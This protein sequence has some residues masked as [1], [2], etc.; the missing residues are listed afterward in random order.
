MHGNE[1]R[2][3]RPLI[4][5][6]LICLDLCNIEHDVKVLGDIGYSALHIDIVDGRFSPSMP[7]GLEM[8]RQLRKKTSLP[9]DAHV[10]AIEPDFFID[11]LL[12]IGVDQLCMHIETTHHIDQYINKIQARG[13]RAGVALNPATSLS[14]LEYVIGKCDFVLLMLIN[15]GYAHIAKETQVP[16]ART[17][18]EDLRKLLDSSG[19]SIPIEIDGRIS[20]ENITS[21]FQA[22]ADIFVGGSTCL[23]KDDDLCSG[24]AEIDKI[25]A[26]AVRRNE[27]LP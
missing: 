15:P 22:G 20:L 18:I 24:K 26:A 2:S 25:I 14:V 5:P 16:Y 8:L 6:S 1:A 19:R 3:A 10:M 17:K 23:R 12:D 27:E 9:F 11:E 4:H 13:V 21:Y 7:L